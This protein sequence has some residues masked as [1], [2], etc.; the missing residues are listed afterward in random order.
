MNPQGIFIDRSVRVRYKLEDDVQI[1]H[2]I[3]DATDAPTLT[4]HK[5]GG[6]LTIIRTTSGQYLNSCMN[7]NHKICKLDKKTV[8]VFDGQQVTKRTYRTQGTISKFKDYTVLQTERPSGINHTIFYNWNSKIK[9]HWDPASML[10][11]ITFLGDN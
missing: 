1:K 6:W 9:D 7:P 8:A 2:S 3:D 11:S 10:N 5:R 4:F